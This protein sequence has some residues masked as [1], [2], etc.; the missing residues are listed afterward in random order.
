MKL[1]FCGYA[2]KLFEHELGDLQY[3]PDGAQQIPK[4]RLFAQYHAPQTNQ[5][6]EEILAQLTS[7]E[8]TIRVLFATVAIGMGV[9][10]Q[11]IRHIIH[12]GVPSSVRQYFQELGRCGRDGKP[13]KATLHY[14]NRDIAK[15]KVGLDPHMRAYCTSIGECLRKQILV[16]LDAPEARPVLP[17]HQ[18]CSECIK[19]CAC[20]DC[21]LCRQAETLESVF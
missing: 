13:A 4:N 21:D 8:S 18:C 7:G 5:M 10:I 6:K 2:Y 20:P 16:F 9:N 14:N 11:N 15:N 3:F 17:A 12:V 1:R 19:S